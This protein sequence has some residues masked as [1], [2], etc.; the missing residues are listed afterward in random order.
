MA[1]R[2]RTDRWLSLLQYDHYTAIAVRLQA[3]GERPERQFKREQENDA[4]RQAAIQYDRQRFAAE[5]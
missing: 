4:E 2:T 5:R 1:L 3:D